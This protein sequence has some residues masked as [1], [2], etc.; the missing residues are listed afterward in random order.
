M[1]AQNKAHEFLEDPPAICGK[2]G[3]KGRLVCVVPS[4]CGKCE[5]WTYNCTQCG[6]TI[7][8]IKIR[9]K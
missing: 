6:A 8:H 3:G 9:E 4:A 1:T 5:I 2:C 7:E